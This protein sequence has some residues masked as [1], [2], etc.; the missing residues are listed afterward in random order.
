MT[1]FSIPDRATDPLDIMNAVMVFDDP[2]RL[3]KRWEV[4]IAVLC[5]KVA[6]QNAE[7]KRETEAHGLT[8]GVAAALNDDVERLRAEVL[9]TCNAVKLVIGRRDDVVWSL[10]SDADVE[11]YV[12]CVRKQRE[13]AE[14]AE[15]E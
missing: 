6:A 4:R 10:I 14:A 12:A 15:G 3:D 7:L 13:A 5:D 11:S 2:P 1:S 9:D 8:A